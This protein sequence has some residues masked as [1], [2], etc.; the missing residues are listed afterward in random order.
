[1]PSASLRIICL[2]RICNQ[3]RERF[4]KSCTPNPFSDLPTVLVDEL[5]EL[6]QSHH[7]GGPSKLSDVM[8]LL[9]SGRLTCLNLCPFDLEKEFDLSLKKI[10]RGCS[11]P[12]IL[13]SLSEDMICSIISLNPLLEEVHLNIRTDFEVFRKCHNLRIMR[14]YNRPKIFPFDFFSCYN[15]AMPIDLSVLSSLRDLEVLFVPGMDTYT[16]VKVLGICPKL[17]SLGF[18][19]SLDAMEEIFNRLLIESSLNFDVDSHFQLRRCV[20]G[21]NVN[22]LSKRSPP[23]NCRFSFQV[24]CAVAFCP[25]VEEL[26][27]HTHH[28]EA[29]R[30]L[31]NLQRLTLL[32]IHFRDCNEDFI[33]EFIDL[34][35][36]IGQH[37]KHLSV[38]CSAPFPVYVICDRC[39]QLQSLEIDGPSFVMNSSEAS[40]YFPLKRL[41]LKTRDKEEDK[42][43]FQFLLSSCKSLEELFVEH[44]RFLD[45]S[46]LLQIFQ[47]NPLTNLKVIGIYDSC[48]TWEAFQMFMKKVVSIEIICISS[49]E[50]DYF[51]D[52]NSVFKI[53][54]HRSIEYCDALEK[55][56]FYRR[57]NENR[58]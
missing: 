31:K 5:M 21:S 12:R 3:L 41:R 52:R 44:A 8:L 43:S 14:F 4:W 33:P 19:D 28:K 9:K 30:E 48:L 49:Q 16:I 38:H 27:F 32:R 26:I 50:E 2:D 54:S 42:K 13:R 17:I 56:F 46:L 10:G 55:E 24:R 35:Q 1:M 25:L 11:S 7:E 34:L 47:L 29:L 51:Y 37:L 57:L 45:D 15:H 22:F 39:P 58:F 53:P 20:W 40:S 23:K 18:V 6:A 36:G